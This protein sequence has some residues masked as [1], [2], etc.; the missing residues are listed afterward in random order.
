M[1]VAL[2]MMINHTFPEGG[3]ANGSMPVQCKRKKPGHN[4]ARL[5]KPT[6][7][8]KSCILTLSSSPTRLFITV[9]YSPY[10]MALK[11]AIPSPM[12]M[13]AWLLCG[14]LPRSSSL[15]PLRSTVEM[16]TTPAR[17]ASTPTSFR[18]ENVSTRITAQNTSVHTDEVDVRIVTEPTDVYS[19]HA[20]AK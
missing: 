9:T 11:K 6:S 20:L 15:C 3:H 2:T 5:N 14:K 8:K 12:A 4:K 7:P 16:S 19:R 1:V 13:L 17:D 10:T 18:T